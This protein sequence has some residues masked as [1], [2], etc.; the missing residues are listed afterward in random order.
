MGVFFAGQY[1]AQIS[2]SFA[3][4]S[5]HKRP[6]AIGKLFFCENDQPDTFYPTYYAR[7]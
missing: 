6:M 3:V 1:G 7:I 4:I 2:P 5:P